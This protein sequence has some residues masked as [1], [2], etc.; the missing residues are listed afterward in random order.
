M[1]WL[2]D[3]LA[4]TEWTG[5]QERT[6]LE[7]YTYIAD[8]GGK[9]IRSKLIDAF[10][11]WLK[12]PETDL[13]VI[14]RVVRM[15]HNASLLM[16]D[17]E[18]NSELRRGIPVAHHIYGIPQTINTA[19]YVYFLAVQ[20]LISLSGPGGKEMG[21]VTDELLNLH[22]GQG[23]DLYW[24]DSLTCPTEEEYVQMVLGKTGGLFRIAVKLM[25][26]RSASDTDYVPLVNLISIYFQIRDDYMNLQST[27]YADNKGF[28]EDLTEGKFSFPVVHG[29]RADPSNRQVLNVLQKRTTSHALK[30]HTVEYLR[31]TTKSFEYTRKVLVDLKGKVEKEIERL[32]GNPALEK[33][34]QLL[35]L[36][37]EE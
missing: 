23:M 31:T 12:V 16:D 1:S 25:M 28:A 29:V 18:D 33:I 5:T 35:G 4:A 19:N 17:V 22:R 34:V 7:P 21:F 27:E 30:Q 2:S 8:T 13:D 24:R 15:L 20:E 6:L 32:G 37:E 26:A 3:P 14:R 9:E 10:N 36:P 11:L